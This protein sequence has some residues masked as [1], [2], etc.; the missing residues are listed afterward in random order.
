MFHFTVLDLAP[1][2]FKCTLHNVFTD[3]MLQLLTTRRPQQIIEQQNE[4]DEEESKE[5]RT[6]VLPVPAPVM[7][8]AVT[9]GPARPWTL[10][11]NI[12]HALYKYIIA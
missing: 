1:T 8:A 2:E 3:D 11:N 9:R 5:E 10:V 12:P 7:P 4:T 6:R